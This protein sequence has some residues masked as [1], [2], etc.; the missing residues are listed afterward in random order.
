MD[1]RIKPSPVE[2]R[3]LLGESAADLGKFCDLE[4]AVIITDAN[5]RARHPQAFPTDKVIEV[6]TEEAGKTLDTVHS[7]YRDFLKLGIDRTSFVVGIGGGVV[8]D[9]A[10]FAASTYMRGLSFGF[11]PTTLLAQADAA[12][13]GK[14]GVNFDGFKNL[15]GTFSQP[16]FV[17]CDP[18]FL[19]TLPER[20]LKNGLAE[21]VKHAAIADADFFSFLEKNAR[22][23]FS[24]DEAILE[25][26]VADSIK[27]K[28]DIVEKDE[29]E[30]DE[31]RKLNFGHTLGHAL[32]KVHGLSH[33]EAV[34]LG[35]IAAAR[36]S[37]K[38]GLA[39]AKDVQRLDGL[40]DKLGF[41]IAFQPITKKIVQ[42]IKKDKKR[43]K[44]KIHFVFLERI[45]KATIKK[46]DLSDLED[47]LDDLRQP[48]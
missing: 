33:G 34:A 42:A 38:R 30:K 37:E 44:E 40:L 43:A 13:G 47:A 48:G 36:L 23:V 26:V 8:C 5:V 12:I 24:L 18:S 6:P 25:K 10:G 7:I 46:T 3:V 19:K 15:V 21:A 41:T 32:E 28:L 17:L 14:N 35:M 4:N 39:P 29:K 1:F 45:G 2:C 20:E 27:I 9:L 16:R 22:G 11:V 31:R